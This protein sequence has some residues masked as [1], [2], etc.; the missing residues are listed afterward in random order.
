VT[1]AQPWTSREAPPTARGLPS[2]RGSA[3]VV[4]RAPRGRLGPW[5]LAWPLAIVAVVLVA[6]TLTWRLMGAG[7][8]LAPVALALV[9]LQALD[10]AFFL[11][12]RQARALSRAL[13]E[14]LAHRQAPSNR[15]DCQ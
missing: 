3:L 8:W 6:M 1:Q 15:E 10:V 9:T 12:R 5:F 11:P 4:C 7:A 13:G 2:Y 14:A